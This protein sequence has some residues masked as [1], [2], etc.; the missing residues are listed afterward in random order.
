MSTI[1]LG[2]WGSTNLRLWRMVDG[3]LTDRA[4]GPGIGQL[5]RS[6]EA[7]LTE[8]LAQWPT[9]Q[10]IILC[11]MAGA[12]NGL[13]E[14]PYA[15]CPV[16]AEE[17]ARAGRRL[18]VAGVDIL[19]GAGVSIRSTRHD[20]MRGEEAQVFGA[21]ARDPALASGDR[22]IVLP[23]T[24]AKWVRLTDGAITGLRT[25]MT[26]ELFALLL[27]SSLFATGTN[28]APDPAAEET[29]FTEGL[30]EAHTQGTASLL[31]TTR[32][33][34]LCAGRSAAW[35]RGFLSGVLIG[36]EVAESARE[37]P[38]PSE[39]S[40]IAA[41]PLAQRYV[42]ALAQF[43]CKAAPL[44]GDDCVLGGLALLAGLQE[45]SAISSDRAENGAFPRPGAERT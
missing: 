18:K 8:A 23:G 35:A 3:A 41:G 34:Q 2:D 27:G 39:A 11:G 14:A 36:G 42:A 20:V 10:R 28:S 31:F 21:V 43:G 29:G 17:W 45:G 7:A 30:D 19:I 13:A 15:P 1:V 5:T 24:H 22:L 25:F 6:P 37:A 12:R 44:D 38:L 16:T 32:A 33:E 9:P 40:V 26:G 4:S